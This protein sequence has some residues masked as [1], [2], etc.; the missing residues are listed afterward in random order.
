MLAYEPKG[1]STWKYCRDS[2]CRCWSLRIGANPVQSTLPW[3]PIFHPCVASFFLTFSS[4]FLLLYLS[5]LFKPLSTHSAWILLLFSVTLCS[6]S[7][8]KFWFHWTS[9]TIPNPP[10]NPHFPLQEPT[11]LS[12][13]F[14]QSHL[15][16]CIWQPMHLAWKGFL[17]AAITFKCKIGAS[18]DKLTFCSTCFICGSQSP[19]KPAPW[20]RRFCRTRG[21][22]APSPTASWVPST[23]LKGKMFLGLFPTRE[24]FMPYSASINLTESV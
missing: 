2:L 17:S 13:P 18:H 24:L 4:L 21:T 6:L 3:R 7:F 10:Q 16:P 8:S 1:E 11:N 22:W 12:K 9:Q 23:P 14:P 15:H 5:H 20:G 19:Q